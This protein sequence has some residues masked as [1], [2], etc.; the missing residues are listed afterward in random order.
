MFTALFR[1]AGAGPITVVEPAERRRAI[2]LQ[3]GA[4]RG[5]VARGVRA[6]A[7]TPSCR[8]APTWSSTP[9]AHC[10][11]RPSPLSRPGTGRAD[12]DELHRSRRIAQNDIT[13]RGLSVLGHTSPTSPSPR[14]YG[15]SSAGPPTCHRSSPIGSAL[16]TC[17]SL[18][19]LRSGEAL[20]VVIDLEDGAELSARPDAARSSSPTRRAATA[21]SRRRSGST[22]PYP[23]RCSCSTTWP[24][25][26][27]PASISDP[28][29]I[30]GRRSAAGASGGARPDPGRRISRPIVWRA[31]RL[32]VG[33]RAAALAA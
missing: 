25:P 28:S 9:L 5:S 7:R 2:A 15:C 29:A 19:L 13:Q 21:R 27:T 31:G 14:R 4:D 6:V 33:A 8:S 17:T 30:S 12:R 11:A 18:E 10:F 3:C 24:T 22:R 16:T 32:R 26:A 1:V 23:S 20:K